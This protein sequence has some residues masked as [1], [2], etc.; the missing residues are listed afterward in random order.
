MCIAYLTFIDSFLSITGHSER[1]LQ[2][3]L[4]FLS[5]TERFGGCS[6]EPGSVRP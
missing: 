2:S 3:L 4:T 6:D 1:Q 5:P